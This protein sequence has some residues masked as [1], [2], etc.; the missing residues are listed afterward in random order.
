MHL[1]L[2]PGHDCHWRVCTRP[3]LGSGAFLSCLDDF[4]LLFFFIVTQKPANRSEL[5]VTKR[6]QLKT[7]FFFF[8]VRVPVSIKR[9][10]GGTKG[11]GNRE[12]HVLVSAGCQSACQ[13]TQ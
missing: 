13:S 8:K 11:G 5:S 9:E 4:L 3:G 10:E 2:S 7:L 12:R 1:F 6:L